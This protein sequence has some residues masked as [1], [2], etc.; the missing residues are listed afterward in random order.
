[1]RRGAKAKNAGLLN[2]IFAASL[3]RRVAAQRSFSL[4][5]GNAASA[6]DAA[7]SM[8]KKISPL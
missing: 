8:G 7:R 4:F 6:A 3:M 2:I 1:M 5:N